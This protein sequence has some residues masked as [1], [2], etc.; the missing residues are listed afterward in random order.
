MQERHTNREQNF[1]E[2]AYT[3]SKYVIPFI[4]QNKIIK[5]GLRILE[6]GC[7]EGGNLKPFLDKGCVCVGVD[8]SESKIESGRK[9]YSS[10]KS[11][12]NIE[13]V[14]CDI[15]QWSCAEKFDVII[16]RDVLEHL[17]HHDT[18]F[19]FSD[20][21]LK[22]DGVFFIGFGPWQSPFG[23]HQQICRNIFISRMPFIHLLPG[24]IF[25]GILEKIREPRIEELIEIKSTRITIE[26][27]LALIDKSNYCITKKTYYL[28]NPNYKIKFGIKPVKHFFSFLPWIRNYITTAGYFIIEH[29][30][31]KY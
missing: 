21:F 13:L 18:F 8:L 10:T 16:L 4:E 25:F 29:E 27:F 31:K 9:I 22:N 24:K 6:I 26:N 3:T 28:F 19:S 15:Y 11:N 14:T 5:E 12:E 17:H 30:K 20:Q 23:G 7:G 1:K 2:Q